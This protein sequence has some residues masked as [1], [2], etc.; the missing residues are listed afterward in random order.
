MYFFV[1][2]VSFDYSFEEID[3]KEEFS[4]VFKDSVGSIFV[5]SF[6]IVLVSIDMR[7]I[8]EKD[9]DLVFGISDGEIF[10]SFKGKI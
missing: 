10:L 8:V 1:V 2:G 4:E 9:F 7:I 3:E 5:K 6:D